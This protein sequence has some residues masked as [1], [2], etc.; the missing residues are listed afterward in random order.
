MKTADELTFT[1][2]EASLKINPNDPTKIIFD[3]I[4][5]SFIHSLAKC[6][7]STHNKLRGFQR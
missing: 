1:T 6:K 4:D 2:C 5:R 3:N 7:Y